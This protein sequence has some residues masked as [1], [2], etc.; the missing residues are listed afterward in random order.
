MEPLALTVSPLKE[1]PELAVLLARWYKD[2]SPDYFSGQSEEDIA[3]EFFSLPA[4]GELPLVLVAM[5]HG[6]P[7]GTIS[8]RETSITSRPELSPWLAGLYVI[9]GLRG[10][11]IG[12]SLVEAGEAAAG[13]MG[14]PVL[15]TGTSTVHAM[16]LTRRWLPLE[17]LEYHGE[18]L[19]LYRKQVT[20]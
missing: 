9:P 17:E 1:L 5:N 19:I 20:T 14:I 2:D 11:G 3:T 6:T 10:R 12:R 16:L 8:L 13:G 7:C 4:N 18:R 15:Y